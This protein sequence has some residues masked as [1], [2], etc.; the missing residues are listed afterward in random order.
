MSASDE[1]D[2]EVAWLCA[3]CASAVLDV[4]APIPINEWQVFYAKQINANV[5]CVIRYLMNG[6]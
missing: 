3:D 5:L 1:D 2:V 4:Y 6:Q